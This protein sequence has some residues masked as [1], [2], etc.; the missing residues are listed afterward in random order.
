VSSHLLRKIWLS[1]GFD[2]IALESGTEGLDKK[3]LQSII[4]GIDTGNDAGIVVGMSLSFMLSE[5]SRLTY[6]L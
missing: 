5:N 6:M 3:Q 1:V 2:A 4:F